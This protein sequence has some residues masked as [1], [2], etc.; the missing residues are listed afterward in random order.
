MFF[1]YIIHSEKHDIYYKGFS[2]DIVKRLE[3]HNDNKGNFTKNKGPWKLIFLKQFDSKKEALQFEKMLKR[4]NRK[5]LDWL[6]ASSK[7]EIR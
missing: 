1:V 4:Q 5:Y 3:F 6:I 2:T 7:N